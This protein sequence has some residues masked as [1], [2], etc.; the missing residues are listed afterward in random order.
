[1]KKK[2]LPMKFPHVTVLKASA[3]SGKTYALARR[4]AFFLLSDSVPKNRLSN[5]LAI[6]FSNNAAKEMKERIL[7]LLKQI[8]LGDETILSELA[9]TLSLP[10]TALQ[11][12]AGHL[13][14]EILSNYSDFQVKTIDSFMTT[15]FKA[16]S[17]EFGFSP[18]FE[19]VMSNTAVMQYAFDLFLRKVREGT[20]EGRFMGEVIDLMLANRPGD[21]SYPWEPT[22][23][24]LTEIGELY[25]KLATSG[26]PVEM[27]DA[28]SATGEILKGI[29]ET[30][31]ALENLIERSGLTKSK[32]SSFDRLASAVKAGRYRD[33][34]ERG[35]KNP[36]V[37]KPR[38]PE[39]TDSYREITD[40]WVDL[41]K[42]IDSYTRIQAHTHYTPYL[43]IYEAFSGIL[44]RVKRHEGKVFIEDVNRWLAAYVDSRVAPEIYCRLGEVI[45]HYLIDE[46]QD[47]S[48]VQW[49]SL[50]PLLENSLSQ[51]GSLFVVGDTKQAIYGFRDA[52]YR[53]MRRVELENLFPSAYHS[54]EE[55]GTNYRSDGRVVDFTEK[56]FHQVLPDQGEYLD[57]AEETGLLNYAQAV[58]PG[59]E[60]RGYVET[61]LL[62]RDDNE[63]PEKEK[64]CDLIVSLLRKGYRYSDIAILTSRND[65]VVRITTW[66][67]GQH[68]PFLSYSSLDVRKRKIVGEIIALLE[69]LDS[70]IDDLAFATFLLG[71]IFRSVLASE[72]RVTSSEEL[73]AMCFGSRNSDGRSLYKA[74]QEEMKELWECYF[75]RLF[76]SSGYM[77]LYDLVVEI[78]RVF[79]VFRLFGNREEGVL[80]KILEVVMGLETKGGG[81]LRS[82]LEY[83]AVAPGGDG[84]WNVDIPQGMDAVKVMT[85]H[86]AKGLGFPVVILVLYGDKSKG[87]RYILKEC[88]DSVALLRLTKGMIS[89]DKDFERL[90]TA[91]ERKEQVN[92]LNSLYVAFTR[93]GS[94]LYVIGVK[95]ERETFPFAL[96]PEGM[97][98]CDG[99]AADVKARE[100]QEHPQA[101]AC[102]YVPQT[103]VSTG[104]E[105]PIH[106]EER[107]RGDFVHRIF[108]LILYVTE[109][110]N[111]ELDLIIR[112][113]CTEMEVQVVSRELKGRVESLLQSVELLPYYERQ[114]ERVVMVERE[115]VDARGRLF[116]VDRIVI[117]PDRATVIEYK[118]GTDRG[119]EG[120][121]Y[122]Q[123]R[124]Y[125]RIITDLYP[126]R[127]VEG[128]IGYVDLTKIRRVTGKG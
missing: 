37:C 119:Y 125:L 20:V 32:T 70:P 19:I 51:E 34:M 28:L 128:I 92:R 47:T 33:L 103:A 40:R 58:G 8:C 36:P 9:T 56:V 82:F 59:R 39:E 10:T 61:C 14:D 98:H 65:D 30:V 23:K 4:F 75:E 57:A 77:P 25:R 68:V 115:L 43:K 97:P 13:V 123:M 52:D 110:F 53:I 45:F 83:A 108:S 117:D 122:P 55:L 46:F 76:R 2:D 69:F 118:T 124:N 105:G 104:S 116:R 101:A 127:E 1:M 7:D 88:D 29:Q 121:H 42:L 95:R 120:S 90:Y 18:D 6:T 91:E 44:E 87:F 84:E 100:E 106:F 5:I 60:G 67:N 102:H 3:G 94:E 113:A 49:R 78:Y 72:G 17:I 27:P 74:F 111:E 66:L 99:K 63:P 11:K 22:A 126:G 80:A 96:I 89:A 112:R 12:K 24:I 114:A 41:E 73:H 16:S 31:G 64:L 21:S 109:D 107:R 85:I 15:V 54:V 93:A 62:T 50:F 79:D 48:P 35:M 81:S 38:K 86:K 26:K 71:D